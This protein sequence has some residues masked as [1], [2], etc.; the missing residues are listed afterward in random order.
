MDLPIELIWKISDHLS[1]KD[2]E[3][4]SLCSRD[5]H[6]KLNEKY[7]KSRSSTYEKLE[8]SWKASIKRLELLSQLL[9]TYPDRSLTINQMTPLVE[10]KYT[11]QALCSVGVGE[12]EDNDEQ[13]SQ[14]AGLLMLFL[15]QF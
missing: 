5:L 12:H 15:E 1:P 2:V 11:H 4:V 10:L 3:A 13:T 9:D 6:N 14:I 7:W 8:N